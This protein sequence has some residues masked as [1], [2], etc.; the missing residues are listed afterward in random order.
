MPGG[1]AVNITAMF[2]DAFG[3][4][5]VETRCLFFAA[6]HVV[7]VHEETESIEIGSS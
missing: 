4:S 6:R 7:A 2:H 1:Y 5:A 3:K